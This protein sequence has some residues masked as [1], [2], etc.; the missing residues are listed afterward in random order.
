LSRDQLL[1]L[2]ILGCLIALF[3][4]DRLRYDV[5]ALLALLV[6]VA[7]G[8]VPADKAFSGFSNPILPLIAAALVVSVAIGQSGAIEILL[9]WLQPMMRSKELQV[10]VL[11]ACVALLSAFM[12]NIGALA[13]FITAAIQVARRNNRPASEFLMPLA[14]ASLLGGSM[15]LIGT[16]PNLLISS[17]RK[18]LTG[19][20]FHM[21]DFTPVSGG[22]AVF[23]I[24]F[25]AVGWRLLPRGRRGSASDTAF[26]IED[27]TSEV[28]IPEKSPYAGRTVGEVERLTGGDINVI[29]VIRDGGRRQIPTRRWKLYS[30]DVLVVEA[31]PQ[32][33]DQFARD[34]NLELVGG[35]EPPQKMP[36]QALALVAQDA[37]VTGDAGPPA[38]DEQKA[39]A[40][41][42]PQADRELSTVEAVIAPGSDLI[43][44]S[45]A[46]LHLR[47]RYGVNVLA[48]GRRGRLRSTRLR[49]MRFKLG[50][51]IVLQGHTGQLPDVLMA[52]GCLPLAERQL[53]L[54]RP[55]KLVMPLAILALAIVTSSLEM[56]PVAIA[57]S[58]AAVV[59]VLL[60][61]VSLKEAYGAVEWPILVLLGCLIPI[62][63][64]V[65]HTGTAKLIATSMSGEAAVMPGFVVLA[66][67]LAVTMLMTPVLHHAAA[68]L[69]MGPIAA[70][71]AQQLGYKIDP[72][73]MAVA[74][75]AGSDFLSPIGHQS[76]TLVM[77]LG[78]YR[79]GDYWKLG[80]PLSL[81]VILLG[82]PLI[83]IVWPLH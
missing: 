29:G 80:L 24:L 36:H 10:G 46:M 32:A 52:L 49:Q 20:P 14:F 68:V 55:R 6:S 70:A 28:R 63:E 62:G 3:L 19:Q 35:E 71:L 45:A 66:A 74:V 31:D 43:D 58:A 1:T 37:R 40:E 56:V 21:F 12:K 69:V 22:I 15:T 38:R 17:V 42:A 83:M 25:L 18:D 11:V 23:G 47:E 75:G 72:F 27:Y 50:D 5:V 16:S 78:G 30:G 39:P 44:H 7:A 34:G 65:D 73:L 4:W 79:F 81:L 53:N 61:L 60:R 48:I 51:A 8:I 82:T 57:F 76:N 9:R 77:G 41:R 2:V 54:G 67:V 26:T 13:I 59:L 33:L 64:A